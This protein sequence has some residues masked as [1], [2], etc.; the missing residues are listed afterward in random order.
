MGGFARGKRRLQA[1]LPLLFVAS[2][3]T[4][5][6][7]EPLA[8]ALPP[9]GASIPE[10]ATVMPGAG[11]GRAEDPRA[12]GYL[13]LTIYWPARSSA[14]IPQSASS[15]GV[16]VSKGKTL[17]VQQVVKR[18]DSGGTA[19]ALVR[20]PIGNNLSVEVLAYQ[21]EN[22]DLA[23]T[24]PL[25]RGSAIGVNILP[26]LATAA[27]LTLEALNVPAI[28]DLSQ[29]AGK[30]GDVITLTGYNFGLVN[31]APPTVT[32]NGSQ[33]SVSAT[34][35]SVDAATLKAT[36]P[37]GAAVG[38]LVVTT[39]GIPS[40][41]NAIFWVATGLAISAPQETWD[42]SPAGTQKAIYG[43]ALSFLATPGWVFSAGRKASDYGTAP[44]VTWSSSKVRDAENAISQAGVLAVS[45]D[46]ALETTIKATL[47]TLE[48]NVVKI[49]PVGV[50]RLV[51][52]KSAMTLN[53]NPPTGNPDAVYA[54]AVSAT[55][56]AT[57]TTSQSF[58]N[59]VTWASSD[60]SRVTVNST[61][62]LSAVADAPGGVAIITATTVD[63]PTRVATVSVT[64]SRKGK[65]AVEVR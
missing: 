33:A 15:L 43:T 51:L 14:A 21:E 52:D 4:A 61:G 37:T 34:V 13:S 59:G 19:K 60:T 39:D 64:V 58:N 10:A 9:A 26:S 44:A 48:S 3:Q 24:T 40:T 27:S 6:G 56:A 5:P 36:V 29:N 55:I 22:P 65:L 42:D 23:T 46:H 1:A 38:R 8:G 49:V 57:V 20:V 47:A 62:V 30:A 53:A 50:D 7:P 35:E 41:S 32:F 17:L 11:A 2:C 31:G 16:K 28:Q 12:H 18:P 25:A 45:A 63:K 54:S